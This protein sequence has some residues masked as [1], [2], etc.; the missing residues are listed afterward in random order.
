MVM[1]MTDLA[2]E[3]AAF[4]VVIDKAAMDALTT[5]EGSVWS[6]NPHV[7]SAVDKMCKGVSRVLKPTGVFLQFSFKQ[8]HFVRRYL[9]AEHVPAEERCGYG[10][11]IEYKTLGEC[12]AKSK[13]YLHPWLFTLWAVAASGTTRSCLS[14]FCYILRKVEFEENS[15]LES[16]TPDS[17]NGQAKT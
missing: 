12:P 10:W 7:V 17:A 8:P 4:D 14:Y 15:R 2:F 11:S 5:D 1:D 6:P 3:D 13:R 16:S 9:M